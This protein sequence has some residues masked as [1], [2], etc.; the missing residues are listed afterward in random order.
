MRNREIE[1]RITAAS[2]AAS[3]EVA[4]PAFHGTDA[5]V[6]ALSEH[7]RTSRLEMCRYV[8]EALVPVY[9]KGGFCGGPPCY[10]VSPEQKERYMGVLGEE[11]YRRT[12]FALNNAR[13]TLDGSL[14]WQPF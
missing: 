13:N 14:E 11:A 9:V 1:N 4:P 8:M 5:N 7:E 2:A 6:L 3:E 10:T 12:R